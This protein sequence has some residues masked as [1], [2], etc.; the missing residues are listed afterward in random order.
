M[1]EYYVWD[2]NVN[3][4]SFKDRN[5][6]YYYNWAPNKKNSGTIAQTI[7]KFTHKDVQ[8]VTYFDGLAY[9]AQIDVSSGFKWII[10]NI[11]SHRD[12]P[13]YIC[14]FSIEN[15]YKI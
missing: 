5:G 10:S 1:D 4:T 6:N 7:D 9:V 13:N 12:I 8:E 14:E 2:G 15:E 11:E 3:L